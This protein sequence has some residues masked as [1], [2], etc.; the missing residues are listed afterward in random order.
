MTIFAGI[1]FFFK[2]N[3]TSEM[4]TYLTGSEHEKNTSGILFIQ[5][6][7]EIFSS[8]D[9]SNYPNLTTYFFKLY[10]EAPRCV[11]E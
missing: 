4:F 10:R 7:S 8:L 1:F 11:C 6:L 5:L 2:Q 3:I 9:I